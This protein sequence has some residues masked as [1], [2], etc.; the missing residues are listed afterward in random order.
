MAPT[1]A[2]P[3]PC[4][5]PTQACLTNWG[6]PATPGWALE[7]LQPVGRLWRVAQRQEPDCESSHGPARAGSP[8][9]LQGPPRQH[10]PPV[11]RLCPP[12]AA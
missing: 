9:R 2:L 11:T 8:G 7:S 3:L 5:H 4:L 12:L 10:C 6:D 1:W